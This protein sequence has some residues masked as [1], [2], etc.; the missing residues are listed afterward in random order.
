VPEKLRQML[1]TKFGFIAPPAV[2]VKQLLPLIP[3]GVIGG[4]DDVQ[5]NDDGS[6]TIDYSDV[7]TS[8]KYFFAN[9]IYFQ[10]TVPSLLEKYDEHP[11]MKVILDKVLM[12]KNMPLPVIKGLLNIYNKKLPIP[13]SDAMEVIKFLRNVI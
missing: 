1:C 10:K 6:V 2:V 8:T 12:N 11:Y 7:G 5:M 3:K 13:P 9:R 4:G